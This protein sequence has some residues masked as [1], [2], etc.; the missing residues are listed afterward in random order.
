MAQWRDRAKKKRRGG[1]GVFFR[2]IMLA[3][4]ISIIS[5]LR[6]FVLRLRLFQRS[7]GDLHR[8]HRRRAACS[9]LSGA[10]FTEEEED[11]DKKKERRNSEGGGM[12]AVAMGR[13]GA[14][15]WVVH[16]L[17]GLQTLYIP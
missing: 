9:A 12:V 3:S 15:F 8:L 1:S 2:S 10:P 5:L 17:H 11:E 4:A 14:R 16:V 13:E 6:A 7:S